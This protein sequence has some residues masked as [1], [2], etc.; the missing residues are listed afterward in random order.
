[1]KS[2]TIF[3]DNLQL[4]QQTTLYNFDDDEK[5]PYICFFSYLL[6]T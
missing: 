1:M 6:K 4:E 3:Q 5:K 2:E